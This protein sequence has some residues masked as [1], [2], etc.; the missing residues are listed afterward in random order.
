VLQL[1]EAEELARYKPN[2]RQPAPTVVIESTVD[3]EK[4]T[5]IALREK[6]N[7]LG[8]KTPPST[9]KA[10]LIAAIRDQQTQ[11]ARR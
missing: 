1:E 5:V 7:G 8:I 6:A 4:L 3:L 11:M 9:K 2:R 10:N